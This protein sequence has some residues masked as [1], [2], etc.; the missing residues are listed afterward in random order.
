MKTTLQPAA[1][2]VPTLLASTSAEKKLLTQPDSGINAPLKVQRADTALT[3]RPTFAQ[4][5]RRK[6][7]T[8]GSDA[9]GEASHNAALARR[10]DASEELAAD[11]SKDADGAPGQ[12]L[13]Q[14]AQPSGEVAA[15]TQS[16]PDRDSDVDADSASADASDRPAAE[17]H[18]SEDPVLL[19]DPH[20]A[21]TLSSSAVATTDP[22]EPGDAAKPF[23][24][25]GALT[26]R[27]GQDQTKS[28]EAGVDAQRAEVAAGQAAA[29]ASRP[30]DL[31]VTS[32]AAAPRTPA[33]VSQQIA[34]F[35]RKP[36]TVDSLN[37]LLLTIDPSVAERLL[38]PSSIYA[39]SLAS[40][41]DAATSAHRYGARVLSGDDSAS[42]AGVVTP[43]ASSIASDALKAREL[44]ASQLASQTLWKSTES[45]PFH[46]LQ[47]R[48]LAS[49]SSSK[50]A[51]ADAQ[52]ASV[53]LATSA[54]ARAESSMQQPIVVEASNSTRL[55]TGQFDRVA[56]AA[57]GDASA[58]SRAVAGVS[59]LRSQ[60]SG[61]GLSASE[62]KR[63]PVER[64]PSF[65]AQLQR[66]LANAVNQ[67]GGSV[68]MR[69]QPEALG[70]LRI[71]LDITSAGV[72]VRL[73][74]SSEGAVRSLR[75]LEAD[76]RASLDA[77]GLKV[78][79]LEVRLDSSLTPASGETTNAAPARG[80]ALSQPEPDLR[81]DAERAEMSGA[82]ADGQSGFDG[83]NGGE[84]QSGRGQQNRRW[85]ETLNVAA[86]G[87]STS[88]AAQESP[89]IITRTRVHVL[90]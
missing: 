38:R 39:T 11:A 7:K 41:A 90:A 78:D 83:H 66:G 18:K 87:V 70:Q 85:P 4:T 28:E 47:A 76:V 69:L 12:L 22:S 65:E 34:E 27:D 54:P 62:P 33:S 25:D 32:R 36:L 31:A 79:R 58:G 50:A 15:R 3:D 75:D 26:A 52:A 61:L 48:V 16:K 42:G 89:N 8:E 21:A 60:T 88:G 71:H 57:A 64:S 45:Q 77:K 2:L 68:L 43:G 67:R 73:D 44:G 1:S 46:E 86:A 55:P 80:S 59:D 82:F 53:R 84:N 29:S 14:A 9:T 51:D 37:E 6:T 5:L 35:T 72:N 13:E 23:Q 20:L 19:L 49:G 81:T 40:E 63:A 10:T 24:A 30:S 17:P 56:P 74:A